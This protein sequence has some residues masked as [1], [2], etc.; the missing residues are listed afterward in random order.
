MFPAKGVVAL[1]ARLV[2]PRFDSVAVLEVVLP[3][4]L[5]LSTIDVFVDT[6][7]VGFIICPVTIINVSIDMDESTL[8]VSSVF[9]P[10][11]R[12]LGAVTPCLLA[13]TISESPLPL[14]SVD[15]SSLES[16]WW[17]LLARLIW[18]VEVPGHGL[19]GFLLR[20]V[21]AATHLFGT[22]H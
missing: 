13:K 18:I 17:P 2:R 6:T 7:A 21:L 22:Y 9:T 12:V 15:S 1:V 8:A 14:P 20:E 16:V 10:L 11:T 3:H 19:A 5:I 4:A